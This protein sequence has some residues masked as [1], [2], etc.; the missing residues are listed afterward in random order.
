MSGNPLHGQELVIGQGQ[1]ADNGVL[2]GILR[3]RRTHLGRR[4]EDVAEAV[5][6]T[7]SYIRS[8]ERGE[9]APA[10]DKA[11]QLLLELGMRPRRGERGGLGFLADGNR[12]VLTFKHWAPEQAPRTRLPL[13]PAIGPFG[14]V[15][16]V[17]KAG[18]AVGGLGG[19]S[20]LR[21]FR[22]RR[23]GVDEGA[24]DEALMGQI[25]QRIARMQGEEL[26]DAAAA[27][28]AIHAAHAAGVGASVDSGLVLPD[29]DD[30]VTV[31]AEIAE[32]ADAQDR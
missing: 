27:V 17:S 10:P 12:W 4:T 32:D 2:G 14:A 7:A 21:S 8:I 25:M 26:R 20:Q 24:S 22:E 3:R 5:G 11:E 15:K 6:V 19:W 13:V 16:A 28:E 30:D 9:R 18:A 1:D 29:A 31:D 23:R